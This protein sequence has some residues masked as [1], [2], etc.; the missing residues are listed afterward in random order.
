MVWFACVL[1]FEGPAA[2]HKWSWK[3]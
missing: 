1:N 3:R 2:G